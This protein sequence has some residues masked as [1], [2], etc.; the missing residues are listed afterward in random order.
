MK[1]F[2]LCKNITELTNKNSETITDK[3]EILKVVQKCYAQ[4]YSKNIDDIDKTRDLM[5]SSTLSYKNY[6]RS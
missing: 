3:N 1:F 6:W 5:K 4:L 2:K